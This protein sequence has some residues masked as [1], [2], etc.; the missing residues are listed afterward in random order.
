MA[1]EVFYPVRV[2][3]FPPPECKW[4]VW[5]AVSDCTTQC[6]SEGSPEENPAGD[7]SDG[8]P[9]SILQFGGT[10]EGNSTQ[11]AV[12]GLCLY[13]SC[14]QRFGRL[15]IKSGDKTVLMFTTGSI[16]K[17]WI[18]SWGKLGGVQNAEYETPVRLL[19]EW[20][21]EIGG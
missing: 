9:R 1:T 21:K 10:P 13:P 4:D 18:Y 5:L 20:L 17:Y 3:S 15:M 6:Y 8:D 12:H 19:K 16:S 7:M 2:T 14:K 11:N